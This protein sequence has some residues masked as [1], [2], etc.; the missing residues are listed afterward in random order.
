MLKLEKI[1]KQVGNFSLSDI[2]V[3]VESGEYFMLIGESGSGKS[4]LL[5]TIIGVLQPDSGSLTLDGISLLH[6]PIQDRNLG[7]V[8]Q[9][10]TLFPHMTVEENIS[11]PLKIRKIKRENLHT[12]IQ[13]LA[14]DTEILPL[15]HRRIDSLSGGEM[16]R[17]TIARTL[18]TNPKV[19][20]LDEPM[21]YLDVQLKRGI[22]SLLR[23]LNRAGQTIIH[24]THDYDEAWSLADKIAIIEQGRILQVGT[25]QEVFEQPASVFVA[26]FIGINNFF[27]ATIDRIS[28][29]ISRSLVKV[30]AF[31]IQLNTSYADVCSCFVI[32]PGS[33]VQV[34]EGISKSRAVN[35]YKGRVVDMHPVAEGFELTVD[36]GILLI[37]QLTSETYQQLQPEQGKEVC[38]EIDEK[39]I[40]IQ[41]DKKI[42]PNKTGI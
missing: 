16:Q 30:G 6:L 33:A 5:D 35:S 28:G 24:V 7:I 20:L 39:H 18:A 14:R 8:Y 31:E 34:T 1:N 32:I 22:R 12:E 40:K 27:K 38:V 15:L 42:L 21:S 10:P 13:R 37:T 19:L 25:P 23:K 11:Y 29:D 9:K 26:N 3:T 2:T 41:T 17:V 36:V 4:M